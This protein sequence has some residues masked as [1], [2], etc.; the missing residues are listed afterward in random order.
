MS[1][2]LVKEY[3]DY[4]YGLSFNAHLTQADHETLKHASRLLLNLQRDIGIKDAMLKSWDFMLNEARE[5]AQEAHAIVGSDAMVWLMRWTDRNESVLDV[6]RERINKYWETYGTLGQ[7][8]R[9][10]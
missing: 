4:L 1:D 2:D 7:P 9:S 6:I 10:K 5:Q 3:A 8:R